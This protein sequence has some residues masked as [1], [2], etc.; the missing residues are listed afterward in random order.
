MGVCKGRRVFYSS[1]YFRCL[2]FIVLELVVVPI[3]EVVL[4]VLEDGV[5]TFRGAVRLFFISLS[6]ST[7]MP[8]P[9]CRLS[10]TFRS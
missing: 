5:R 8:S 10:C 2:V 6:S 4:L 1:Y 7:V 9:I 3:D